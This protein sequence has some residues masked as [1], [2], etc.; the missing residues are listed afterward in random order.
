[1]NRY[2]RILHSPHCEVQVHRKI[3]SLGG[4]RRWRENYIVLDWLLDYWT[5]LFHLHSFICSQWLHW[6]KRTRNSQM[7]T[8]FHHLFL[9]GDSLLHVLPSILFYVT[10][11]LLASIPCEVMYGFYHA[12]CKY[13]VIKNALCT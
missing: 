5:T 12:C 8:Q 2:R 3:K 10:F 13:R 4:R 6:S 1:M 7:C 11:S 9:T